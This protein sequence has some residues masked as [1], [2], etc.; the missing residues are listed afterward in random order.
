MLLCCI[1]KMFE[2]LFKGSLPGIWSGTDFS[3][4]L[5]GTTYHI[6]LF[7]TVIYCMLTIC[8]LITVSLFIAVL[9]KARAIFRE[10]PFF[11]IV[12]QVTI[13]NALNLIIQAICIL[14]CTFLDSTEGG[15]S[16]WYTVGAYMIDLSDI[17]VM[18]FIFLMALNR[19]AVFVLK[20]LEKAFTQKNVTYSIL[21]TWL[22]VIAFF[23]VKVDF[24]PIRMKKSANWGIKD[25][26]IRRH[27]GMTVIILIGYIVPIAIL[28]IY[29]AIYAYIRKR[30]SSV[31]LAKSD[32]NDIALLWQGFIL[33]V[34]LFFFRA[35]STVAPR[36]QTVLWLAWLLNLLRGMS[37]VGNHMLNSILFL[38][39]NRTNSGFMWT[40]SVILLVCVVEQGTANC[41]GSLSDLPNLEELEACAN[42]P[43]ADIRSCVDDYMEVVSA[44]PTTGIGPLLDPDVL[45]AAVKCR[46]KYSAKHG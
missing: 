34:S 4:Q 3:L 46:V 33:A 30:R 36:I 40:I 9:I 45:E 27:V 11:V 6:V 12:W 14:P 37:S 1:S 16:V 17:S 15:L 5:H 32:K 38:I 24:G 8:G 20:P 29:I 39:T 42:V 26:F 28:L 25:F 10:Y 19:F 22:L 7:V 23:I 43:A 41:F 18:C 31:E 2:L 44:N 13:A 35:I 21:L